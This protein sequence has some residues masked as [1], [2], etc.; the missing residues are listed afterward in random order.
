MFNKKSFNTNFYF[1]YFILIFFKYC[2]FYLSKEA[3]NINSVKEGILYALFSF[4]T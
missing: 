4:G 2:V 1:I 3:I